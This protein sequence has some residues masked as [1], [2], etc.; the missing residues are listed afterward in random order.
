[1]E[2]FPREGQGFG[3]SSRTRVEGPSVRH[4]VLA[5]RSLW[6]AQAGDRAPRESLCVPSPVCQVDSP[7]L[8]MGSGDPQMCELLA[9]RNSSTNSPEKDEPLTLLVLRGGGGG[10]YA[11]TSH[12][13]ACLSPG[14]SA[15]LR[16]GDWFETTLTRSLV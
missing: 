1:M 14:T 9:K 5:S 4:P 10:V 16:R 3:S 13:G 7:C 12:P 8:L 2:D 15:V 11:R 6:P